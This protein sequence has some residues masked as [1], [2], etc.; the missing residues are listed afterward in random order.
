MPTFD[1]IIK[2]AFDKFGA[3]VLFYL[4]MFHLTTSY[5]V[6]KFVKFKEFL[7][8]KVKSGVDV[9]KN[10]SKSAFEKFKKMWDWIKERLFGTFD[11]IKK[12]GRKALEFLLKFFGIEL[13]RCG[14]DGALN[15]LPNRFYEV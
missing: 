15:Y 5:R 3:L 2:E 11:W 4:K 13:T 1:T 7:S 8:D 14:A 10:I 6:G 9:V 12:Q